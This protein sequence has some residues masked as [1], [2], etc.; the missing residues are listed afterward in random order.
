MDRVDA[1]FH[2]DAYHLVDRQ[3]GF[4]RALAATDLI[5][6]VRLESV[7]REL[8]LLGIDRDGAD[9]ELGR[10]AKDADRDLGTVGDQQ[11]LD[12]GHGMGTLACT[13]DVERVDGTRRIRGSVTHDNREAW[14]RLW[15]RSTAV[16]HL[17][18]PDHDEFGSHAAEFIVIRGT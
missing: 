14:A 16:A 4:E 13:S 5:G 2:S 8:V 10:R 17:Q 9:A 1:G 7:Q 6:F 15:S 18:D 3:I 12:L 11:A